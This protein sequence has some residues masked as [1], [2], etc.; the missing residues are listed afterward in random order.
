MN[1][2]KAICQL[3]GEPMPPGEEMFNYHGYSGECP[4]PPTSALAQPARAQAGV[5]ELVAK[6]R[7]N[8][9][10][11]FHDDHDIAVT[12]R[13]CAKQLADALAALGGKDD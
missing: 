2:T 11:C 7:N 12:Y 10:D 13:H 9:R 4:K 5:A 3:C 8:A 6:W 1:D